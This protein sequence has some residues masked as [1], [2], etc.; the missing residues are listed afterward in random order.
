MGVSLRDVTGAPKRTKGRESASSTG[1][2]QVF[3]GPPNALNGSPSGAHSE[4]RR[5]KAA[6][7]T[8]CSELWAWA[9]RG[10]PSRSVVASASGRI[11][12]LILWPNAPHQLQGRG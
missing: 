4:T 9:R 6:R 12:F 2:G 5:A 7:W 8:G 11:A 3:D 10:S 1:I